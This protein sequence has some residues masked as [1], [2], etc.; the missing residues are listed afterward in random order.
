MYAHKDQS[1]ASTCSCVTTIYAY[2][3]GLSNSTCC[4]LVHLIMK[5]NY[6]IIV[7]LYIPF[8]H[9]YASFFINNEL[10][11][12][13]VK[14]TRNRLEKFSVEQFFVLYREFKIWPA[15]VIKL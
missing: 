11:L 8:K 9:V 13:V 4:Q 1:V 14:R 3:Q 5:Y 15:Q 2:H 12:Q 10:W 6:D 7:P